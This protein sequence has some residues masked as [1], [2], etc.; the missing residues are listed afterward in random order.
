MQSFLCRLPFYLWEG[1]PWRWEAWELARLRPKLPDQTVIL[2]FGYIIL[3]IKYN[4]LHRILAY[5]YIKVA[6]RAVFLIFR[7]SAT[8]AIHKAQPAHP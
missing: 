7:Y 6:C 1:S 3:I 8:P 5:E 4:V 2:I